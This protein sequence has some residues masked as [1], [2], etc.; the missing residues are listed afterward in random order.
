MEQGGQGKNKEQTDFAFSL[1]DNTFGFD[2]FEIKDVK[3]ECTLNNNSS[4]AGADKNMKK[5]VTI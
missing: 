4:A 2:K 1:T 5:G 3:S